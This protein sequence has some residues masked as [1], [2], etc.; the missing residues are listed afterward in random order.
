MNDTTTS[1]AA[2]APAPG[3]PDG[4][5]ALLRG[6]HVSR[7]R[8]FRNGLATTVIWGAVVLAL[9]PLALIVWQVV[10]EGGAQLSFAFLTEDIPPQRRLGPG[11]GPAVFGTLMITAVAT[12]IAVPL[13]ILGAVYLHEYGRKNRTAR[14]IRFLANVMSGVPSIVMGLFIYVTVVLLTGKQTG[15]AGSLALAALMLPIV[16]RSTEEM[17]RLVPDEMRSASYA[18]GGRR[19]R[20]I[21]SIVLPAALPGIV[22]GSLLAVARAAGETAPVL[23]VIGAVRAL[24]VSWNPL[25]WVEQLLGPNTTLAAQ[26][27]SN[28]KTGF[29]GANQRA[30]GA[31]LTLIILVFVFTVA[32]RLVSRRFSMK[33]G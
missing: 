12:F 32:A 31:A 25:S 16:I 9:V 11:M 6:R 15:L 26:I 1:P 29:E 13:G 10:S 21:V 18:L 20:T 3:R 5:G 33:M 2:P 17:L 24:N 30:W 7:A 23:F 27:F 14:S 22:S 4:A 28:A 19:W 8:R